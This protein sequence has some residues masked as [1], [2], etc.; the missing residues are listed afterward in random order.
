[1]EAQWWKTRRLAQNLVFQLRGQNIG[2]SFLPGSSAG[3]KPPEKADEDI[4]DEERRK[5][6]E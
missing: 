2:L 1:M 5:M 6:T 3:L 4:D